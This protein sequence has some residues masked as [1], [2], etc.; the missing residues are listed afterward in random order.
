VL[1]D[2]EQ[3]EQMDRLAVVRLT[4]GDEK[5]LIVNVPRGRERFGTECP[6]CGEQVTE[7][8]RWQMVDGRWSYYTFHEE[9]H[10]LGE[11]GRTRRAG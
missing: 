9:L 10:L 1:T 11:R 6:E 8:R 4:V 7:V 3:W 2:A 5:A